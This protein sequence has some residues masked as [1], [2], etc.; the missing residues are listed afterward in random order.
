LFIYFMIN[1]IG[2]IPGSLWVLYVEDKFRWN[3][4]MVGISF[5]VFGILHA[6]TQ[7]FLTGPATKRLGETRVLLLGMACDATG[8][9][10]LALALP[11]WMVFPLIP[12]L[13]A[14]GIAI[15][16][17]QTLLSKQVAENNQGE[18]QGILVSLMSIAAIA[19]PL[20]FTT[21]YDATKSHWIGTTWILG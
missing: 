16:A 3:T 7:A 9:V 1:F 14:G 10:L 13:C 8:F 17:L 19:G 12:I 11:G 2:Q 6:G 20:L 5:A 4:V 18:L 15:P 21:I